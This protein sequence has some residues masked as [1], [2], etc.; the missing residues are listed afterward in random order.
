MLV[1]I[2]TCSAIC[3]AIIGER[4]NNAGSARERIGARG[5]SSAIKYANGDF[6]D[7]WRDPHAKDLT[8]W[9]GPCEVVNA[10]KQHEGK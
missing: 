5:D 9:R 6:C 3:I 10:T 2:V 4:I 1:R 8:G 7:I